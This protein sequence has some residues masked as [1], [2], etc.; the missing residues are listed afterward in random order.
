M[1]ISFNIQ[2]E[3]EAEF[4]EHLSPGGVDQLRRILSTMFDDK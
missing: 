4:K 2:K 1:L 3:L